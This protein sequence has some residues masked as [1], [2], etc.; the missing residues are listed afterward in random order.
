MSQMPRGGEVLSLARRIGTAMGA[1]KKGNLGLRRVE[2]AG[3]E[4]K[5]QRCQ[6]PVILHA[7]RETDLE[8]MDILINRKST[9]SIGN[10]EY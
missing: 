6:N 2:T 5:Q 10:N 1:G 3:M 4:K 8:R 9:H 7:L